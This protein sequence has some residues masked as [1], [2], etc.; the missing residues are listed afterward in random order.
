MTVTA[1]T[2]LRAPRA[3]AAAADD[4]Q[5]LAFIGLLQ[6]AARFDGP[7]TVVFDTVERVEAVALD[8]LTLGQRALQINRSPETRVADVARR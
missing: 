7:A 4:L 5:D 6:L 2:I 8:I 1:S 3:V